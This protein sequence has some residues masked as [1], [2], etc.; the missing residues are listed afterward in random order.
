MNDMKT[1]GHSR[2]RAKKLKRIEYNECDEPK[3]YLFLTQVYR[4]FR[5][6]KTDTRDI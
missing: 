1:A 2:Q 4:T 6:I 5:A 3:G